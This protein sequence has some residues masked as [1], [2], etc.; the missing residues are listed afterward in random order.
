[1]KPGAKEVIRLTTQEKLREFAEAPCDMGRWERRTIEALLNDL[2]EY[3]HNLNEE[4][5]K[6]R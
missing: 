1:L 2:E 3:T 5:P 4:E 6:P